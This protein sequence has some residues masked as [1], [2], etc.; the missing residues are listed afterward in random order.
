MANPKEF[1]ASNPDW[2]NEAEDTPKSP[3]DPAS[4]EARIRRLRETHVAPLTAYVEKLRRSTGKGSH[5]PNFDP[6]DGGTRARCP[7][8]FEAPGKKAVDSGF[9]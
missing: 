2:R 3:R 9:V 4:R 6:L 8:V 5:I 7:F 1:G